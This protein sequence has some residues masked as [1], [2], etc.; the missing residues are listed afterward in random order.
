MKAITVFCGSREGSDPVYMREAY[1][2]GKAM[3]ER[4]LTLVY[5]GAGIG[6]MRAMADGVL[7]HGGKVIGVMPE[8]L[9]NRERSYRRLTDLRIVA[10]MPT[11]KKVMMQEG[12]AFIAFPGGLGTLEEWFEVYSWAKIGYHDKPCCLLNIN[13]YYDS[14]LALFGHMIEADFAPEDYLSGIVHDT[15]SKRLIDK[16]HQR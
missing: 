8:K 5:G 9:A 16:I 14:L 15:D 11:R 13:G 12:D 10:D 6:C 1:Q 3:A 2:L 7:D 4:E